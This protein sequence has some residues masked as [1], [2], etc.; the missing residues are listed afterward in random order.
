MDSEFNSIFNKEITQYKKTLLFYAKKCDWQRFKLNAGQLFDYV[1]ST[2]MSETEKRF[3]RITKGIVAVLFIML[4]LIVKMNPERYPELAPINELMTLAAVAVCC[5]E[6]YFF[7]NFRIYIK[8]K[9]FFY[10]KRREKFI[11][12]IEQDFKEG[13]VRAAA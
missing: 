10:K 7:Y 13:S 12:N 1:E 11:R 6:V 8:A 5:F 9:S 2:E 3:F 4:I